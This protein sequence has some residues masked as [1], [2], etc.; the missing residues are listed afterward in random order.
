MA[1]VD[2]YSQNINDICEY[3]GVS[4]VCARYL[5]HRAIR[6]KRHDETYLPWSI[7][8]QNALVKADKCL[9]VEWD[10]IMFGNEEIMLKNYGIIIDEMDEQ[11]FRWTPKEDEPDVKATK[12]DVADVDP[13]QVVTKK[14]ISTGKPKKGK[15]RFNFMYS[16]IC[17]E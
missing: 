1:A 12:S 13:W 10:K 2:N 7:K 11:V 17:I 15:L 8:L 14:K 4:Q 9:G 5:Y 3:F 6:S 16:G